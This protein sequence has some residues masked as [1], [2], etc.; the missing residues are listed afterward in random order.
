MKLALR[1]QLRPPSSAAA[2]ENDDCH[3]QQGRAL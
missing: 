1:K 2:Q 3:V